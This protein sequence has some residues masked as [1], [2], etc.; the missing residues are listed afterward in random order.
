MEVD[1]E[2]DVDRGSP[3]GRA[4]SPA[5]AGHRAALLASVRRALSGPPDPAALLDRVVDCVRAAAGAEAA[6]VV[7]LEATGEWVDVLHAK[8]YDPAVLE[9][10]TRFRVDADLPLAEAIRTERSLWIGEPGGDAPERWPSFRRQARE[11]GRGA[12]A[13]VPFRHGDRVVGAVGLSFASP[14]TFD[15]EQVDL[16]TAVVDECAGALCRSDVARHWARPVGAAAAGDVEDRARGRLAFLSAA[17]RE[18]GRSLER[19]EVI[20]TLTELV[21]PRF[22]DW[23][24]VLLAEGDELVAATLVHRDDVAPRRATGRAGRYRTPIDAGSPV[25]VAYRTASALVVQGVDDE[26][27]ARIRA[28]PELAERLAATTARVVV[29]I[30]SARRTH[31]VITLAWDDAGHVP[32]DDDVTVALELAARAAT[33]LDNADRYDTQRSVAAM[34]QQAVLPAGLPRVPG[35]RLAARYLPATVHG[36]VGGDWYDAFRLRDGRYGLCVGDVVG[37]G[38]EAAARMG[39]LRQAL[40]VYALDGAPPGEVLA[41]LNRFAVDTE[42]ADF[43]TVVY[44]TLDPGARS[45][46]WSS[47]G[48]LP[49]LHAGADGARFLPSRPGLPLGARP[50]AT[51]ETTALEHLRG[52]LVLFSD[53][54]VE[55]RASSIDAGL[56]RLRAATLELA[57]LDVEALCDALVDRVAPP[58]RADDLSMLA[59]EIP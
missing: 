10:F 52:L 29:P 53:G 40:R 26:V 4:P 14:R 50:D 7:A 47:A 15:P 49:P 51:Y 42:L 41:D 17:T 25:S 23:S 8:G 9:R 38:V 33:A 21:V 37:H 18:L 31:G 24:S 13:C 30:A 54:L 27:E 56:D 28:F 16:L 3:P 20:E 35:V 22:A 1:A 57:H 58:D 32:D 36:H 12:A 45:L 6:S 43:T 39:Q 34:L 59:V 55:D 44:A 48:H 5:A 19:G 46:A 2:V 11:S